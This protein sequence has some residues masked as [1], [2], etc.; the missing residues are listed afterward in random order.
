M[1]GDA[2]A[3]H[4]ERVAGEVEVGHGV[5]DHLVVGGDQVDQRAGVHGLELREAH[6]GHGLLHQRLGLGVVAQQQVGDLGAPV[7]GVDAGLGEPLLEEGV[8]QGLVG[9][10]DLGHEVLEVDHLGAAAAQGVGERVVLLLRHLQERD[11]V[12]QQALQGV[13]G[14]VEKL[15]AR[16]VQQHLLQGADLAS[17]VYSGHSGPPFSLNRTVS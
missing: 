7:V 4:G 10:D 14:E 2:V 5:D 11:V 13:G 16:S 1:D 12:E 6:A 15:V 17:D 9:A 3:D 8:A